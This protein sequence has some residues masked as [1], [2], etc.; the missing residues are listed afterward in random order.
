[1]LG[2]LVEQ[3]QYQGDAFVI[4]R[5]GKPAAAMV[6]I[7]VYEAWKRQRQEFFDQI[8]EL[9]QEAG[10]DPAE[11]ECLAAEAVAAARG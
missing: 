1:M 2:A 3:V 10:L 11:A 7:P 8:R 6:P 4:H 5:H 9:Q